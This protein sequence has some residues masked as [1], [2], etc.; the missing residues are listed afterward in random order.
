MAKYFKL[1][2]NVP[3]TH[4]DKVREAIG[5]IGAGKIGT[6]GFCSFSIRGKGRSIPLEGAHPS[7]GTIGKMEVIEEEKIET[8][9]T[10]DILQKVI[11]TIK[12]VHPYEEPA[13][14]IYPIEIV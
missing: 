13:I 1:T 3:I 6:Y 4:A 14:T 12:A 8:F 7:I 9:C 2:V 5:K 11:Q 10:E